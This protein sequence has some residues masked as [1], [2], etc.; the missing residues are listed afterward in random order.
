GW[1]A[2]WRRR[3]GDRLDVAPFQK[4]ASDFPDI[5]IERFRRAVQ[6]IEPDGRRSQGAE[7]VFRS[8][9]YAPRGGAWLWCYAR[10]PGFAPL[11]EGLYRFV[12][13]R[14][15]LF[16]RLTEAMWG[17]HVVPPGEARTTWIFLRLLALVYVA[18]FGSLGVQ[19][20]G[21][22]GDH[23][24]LSAREYLQGVPASVGPIRFWFLPTFY[25]LHMSDGVLLG[26]CVGGTALAVLLL[27]GA[28]PVLCLAGLWLSYLSLTT[29]VREFMWFQWDNLLLEAG[30]LAL[31]VAPWRWWSRPG[32]DP[33]PSRVGRWL[34]RWLLFRLMFSSAA[35]K[36][37]SGDPTWRDLTALTFHY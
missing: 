8:L 21:L 13:D 25:W 23:G 15:G 35:V 26:L 4:V 31:F 5:P 34:P 11:S 2:R 20:V 17:P 33:P 19:I 28:A 37:S 10:V 18:A 16:T 9:A 22:A 7:A 32:S 30:F 3:T 27:V 12:A 6:L 36:L 29:V 24:I 14:R 1:V